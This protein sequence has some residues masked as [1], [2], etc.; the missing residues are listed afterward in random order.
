[1]RIFSKASNKLIRIRRFSRDYLDRSHLERLQ[2][3]AGLESETHEPAASART[4]RRRKQDL[5]RKLRKYLGIQGRGKSPR[6]KGKGT[7]S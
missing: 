6:N 7:K 1:M 5:E 3:I 4:E 2:R